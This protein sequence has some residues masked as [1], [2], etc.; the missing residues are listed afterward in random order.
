MRISKLACFVLGILALVSLGCA[1]SGTNGGTSVIHSPLAA[2]TAGMLGCDLLTREHPERIESAKG[3]LAAA[4]QL[5]LAGS[6]YSAIKAAVLGSIPDKRDAAYAELVLEE[7]EPG[8][9]GNFE[10]VVTPDSQIGLQ[11]AAAIAGCRN[12]LIFN[13]R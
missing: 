6:A 1:T 5:L 2:K 13:R 4:E 12:A 11:I 8:L 7:I 3:K 9:Q 10:I